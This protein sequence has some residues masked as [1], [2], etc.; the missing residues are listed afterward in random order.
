MDINDVITLNED[1]ERDEERLLEKQETDQNEASDDTRS[2]PLSST[3]YIFKSE[4]DSGSSVHIIGTSE[5]A[6]P[7]NAENIDEFDDISSNIEYLDE[8]EEEFRLTE[9]IQKSKQKTESQ[10]N[11]AKADKQTGKYTH[12]SNIKNKYKMK[13]IEEP[14]DNEVLYHHDNLRIVL[15]CSNAT[16]FL[17]RGI[18]YLCTLCRTKYTDPGDLKAHTLKVHSSL[19]SQ[20]KL[21][22]ARQMKRYIV[23]L[24]IT[25][26]KCK[27][28]N[29]NISSLKDLMEHLYWKHAEG[30]HRDLPNHI[31]PF[32][33]DSEVLRC[34]ECD[35]EF[36]NFK[37]LQ[38]HMNDH[39]KNFTCEVCDTGYVTYGSLMQHMRLHADGEYTCEWC[40]KVFGNKHKLGDHVKL[41]HLGR[42]KRNKCAYC[43]MK[44]LL[45]ET[46]NK[47]MEEEHGLKAPVVQCQ[48]CL[49]TFRST[50][51]LTAHM[52]NFHLIGERNYE[53]SFCER[54][55]SA[56]HMLK[57]HMPVHSTAKNFQCVVCEK[58]FS[59]K[60]TLREHIRIHA[61][62]RRFRCEYCGMAFVQ[63]CSLTGHL[64]SK[65]ADKEE[66]E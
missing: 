25:N 56:P 62:D 36:T 37:M 7:S 46:R 63:K 34:T 50:R 19:L 16:T 27:L 24:D 8:T 30:I 12:C 13:K 11:K 44:F 43:D 1:D 53:C 55:F 28:C 52:K 26:L 49:K 20:R 33:F 17:C 23:K 60:K 54:R 42:K 40:Q 15:R 10:N 61:N 39:Y 6:S 45:F 51:Y 35:R 14:N 18:W 4:S 29:L 38:C 65:H 57:A 22:S 9:S 2:S 3:E 32:K 59:R 58:A 31:I 41:V 21:Y 48:A 66:Q 5:T 64:K 47:H